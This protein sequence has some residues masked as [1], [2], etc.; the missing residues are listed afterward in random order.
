MAGAHTHALYHHGASPLHRLPAHVKIVAA[1]AMVFAVVAT[2]REA[3]WVFGLQA[4]LLV[5]MAVIAGLRPRFVA[6]RLLFEIPFV[7]VALLLPFFGSGERTDVAGVSLSV[8]GL[9]SMWNIIAKAT[10]GLFASIILASTTQMTDILRGFDTLRVPRMLTAIM[11]FMIRYIDVVTGEFRRMR[12]AMHARGYQPTW[13]GQ[14]GPYARGLGTLFLRSYER[15]E[16]V[17]L[18]MV[19]RGYTGVMPAGVTDHAAVV[20]WAVVLAAPLLAWGA[21]AVAWMLR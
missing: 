6:P 1:F 16:R 14:V 21:V 4:S 2:P 3:F 12:V 18:S 15:G 10:L 20:T 9:W 13:L 11:G 8:E 17:Y 19:S 5:G 7:A